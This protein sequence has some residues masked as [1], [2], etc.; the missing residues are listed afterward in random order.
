MRDDRLRHAPLLTLPPD[1][2]ARTDSGP[3]VRFGAWSLGVSFAIFLGWAAFVPIASSVATTGTLVTD[4]RNKVVQHPTGGLV[5]A[6]RVRSGDRVREGDGLIELD[7]ARARAELT[8]LEARAR[9]LEA[10]KSRLLAQVKGQPLAETAA[11]R[12]SLRGDALLTAS[13][14]GSVER[15]QADVFTFGRAEV[16]EELATL[17]SKI[18]TLERQREGLEARTAST[19]EMLDLARMERNRL[20]P[21][22]ASGYVAR[23]RLRDRDRAVIEMEGK[24]VSQRQE[25]RAIET[26]IAEIRHERERVKASDRKTSSSEL[27]RIATE[28]DELSD[29]IVAARQGLDMSV[30]RAPVSGTVVK[31]AVSTQGGVVG[32]GDV[33]AEIVPDAAAIE[34]TARIAP[35]DIAHVDVGDPARLTL[36]AFTWRGDEPLPAEV[37]HVEGDAQTDERTGETYFAVSVRPTDE[38]AQTAAGRRL[39]ADMRAGMKAELHIRSGERTFV[40]YLFEPIARSFRSAFR[41]N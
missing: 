10:A 27:S 3:V 24:L 39:V 40:S 13:V 8:R 34:V 33:L 2:A 17:D 15:S 41:E 21:L 29:Q 6:I 35:A 25:E 7:G 30:L 26:R 22:V 16:S 38:A 28:L 4:G 36:T 5:R 9:M 37:T 23:N 32:A 14:P 20:E 18:E 11:P 1:V 19:E 31:M 12:W